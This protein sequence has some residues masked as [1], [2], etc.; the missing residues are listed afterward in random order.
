MQPVFKSDKHPPDHSARDVN[1]TSYAA[2]S[3]AHEI[4]SSFFFDEG[5]V[6]DILEELVR[7]AQVNNGLRFS[8]FLIFTLTLPIH[9]GFKQ[10]FVQPHLV[11]I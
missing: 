10:I 6:L 5:R 9:L 4:L 2:D 1:S 8:P 3:G 7:P 11:A